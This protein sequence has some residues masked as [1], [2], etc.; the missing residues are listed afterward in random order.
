MDCERSPDSSDGSLAKDI[1]AN[2]DTAVGVVKAYLELCGY[3]VLAELPVREADG[4]GYR[5]VTDLDI[6]AVRFSHPRVGLSRQVTSPLEVFLGVDPA[7]HVYEE[8]VDVIVGEVKEGHAR[9]NPSLRR[10][11]TLA[12]ALRRVGCCPESRIQEEARAIVRSGR[13]EMVMSGYVRCQVRLVVFGG[14]GEPGERGVQTL[15]LAQCWQFIEEKLQHAREVLAGSH[16][17]DP[18]LGFSC[19]ATK[20]RAGWISRFDDHRRHPPPAPLARSHLNK[21]LSPG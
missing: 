9:L 19:S 1:N 5:D 11:E 3:F 18:I 4:G 14:S 8:G 2:M 10:A 12:F 17:K 15:L 20:S 16:F 7:L 21:I 13:R 6:V